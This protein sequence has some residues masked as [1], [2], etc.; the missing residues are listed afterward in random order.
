MEKVI[1]KSNSAY[2]ILMMI[3]GTIFCSLMIVFVKYLKHLPVMEIVFFRNFFIM[4]IIPFM[5]KKEKIP[6]W[7][8]NKPLILFRSMCS[9]I[10]AI[11]YFYTAK[12]MILTDA[13]TIKQL[14]PVFILFM[15]A[16][17]LKEKINIQKIIIFFLA[18]LGALFIIKPGFNLDIFPAI[19][20]LFGTIIT[21]AAHIALRRLRL[22]DHPLVIVNYFGYV[23]GLV[24]LSVMLFQ[25]NYIVPDA[26]SIL[27]LLLLGLTG[28]GV[29]VTFVKAYQFAPT[30]L[31]SFYLYLQIIFTTIIG[32]IFFNEIPGI[33]SIFGASIIIITGYFNYQ[34][35]K[36][37]E[38]EKNSSVNI[39]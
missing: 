5:L 34:F 36:K 29:Q 11:T 10:G 39:S 2:G 6:I 35:S 14:S 9:V 28:L 19:V 38:N 30:S 33:F 18:F 27:F 17:F 32:V 20:G 12:T 22:T 13:V 24:A 8:N 15:A 31:V 7:G 1:S 26:L 23:G 4:L 37:E 25:G 16:I 21:A 3:L